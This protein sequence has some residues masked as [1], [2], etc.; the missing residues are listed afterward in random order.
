MP[1]ITFSLQDG[2]TQSLNLTNI[3]NILYVS[4][5]KLD[6][7]SVNVPISFMF[8]ST[9]DS[10]T[11]GD[12]LTAFTTS[13]L[14]N[15]NINVFREGGYRIDDVMVKPSFADTRAL[16]TLKFCKE[17]CYNISGKTDECIEVT[18]GS[19]PKGLEL[20][21][22]EN[23]N[24]VIEG[25]A[26]SD[27]L[28]GNISCHLEVE[29]QNV[30]YEQMK[31]S[32]SEVSFEDLYKGREIEF[33]NIQYAE[34]SN[35]FCVCDW[36]IDDVT[37]DSTTLKC[38]ETYTINCENRTR[39][40][41]D[42]MTDDLK[43]FKYHDK[44]IDVDEFNKTKH[45]KDWKGKLISNDGCT[46]A[47]FDE[48]RVRY[49]QAI[50]D[51]DVETCTFTLGL[52]SA[53]GTGYCET[54]EFSLNVRRNYDAIRDEMIQQTRYEMPYQG[55]YSTYN[56][57]SVVYYYGD[58]PNASYITLFQLPL[59]KNNGTAKNIVIS[60]AEL[61]LIKNDTTEADIA[62]D[63]NITFIR[64]VSGNSL[65]SNIELNTENNV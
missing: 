62:V 14:N 54:K 22:N 26:T 39:F 25:Y 63:G 47:T 38:I 19:L 60:Y 46:V 6:G 59:T 56:K 49:P 1:D 4:F 43:I 61:D 24:F 48:V 44:R 33:R 9:G 13:I 53:S 32:Q 15:E 29:S 31:K 34:S 27:N 41:V 8:S 35:Q 50:S 2:S 21:T 45:D 20:K 52:C 57:N 18:A 16:D 42:E 30:V 28:T 5:L 7:T 64:N 12:F 40:V 17:L 55:N 58:T 36:I 37:K 3:S 23:G 11:V 65:S 10:A 51:N